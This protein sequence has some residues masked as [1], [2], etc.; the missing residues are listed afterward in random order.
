MPLFRD[1]DSLLHDCGER[2]EQRALL[3]WAEEVGLENLPDWHRLQVERWIWD[4]RDAL[5]ARVLDIGVDFPRPGLERAVTFGQ[6]DERVVGDIHHLPFADGAFDGI[7]CTETLEH[8]EQP[9]AAAQELHRALRPGGLLLVTSPFFWPWHGIPGVYRDFWRMT[10]EG[11]AYL[12]RR[13]SRVDIVRASWTREGAALY[14]LLR[15]FEGWGYRVE[16]EA[17]T[18]YLCAATK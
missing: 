14:D 16:V 3:A 8:T 7:V 10:H 17:A 9:D 6:H 1:G 13:F 4:R 2:P 15:K 11:W 18:G 12:L 5:G